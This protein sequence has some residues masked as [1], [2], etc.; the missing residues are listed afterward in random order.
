MSDIWRQIWNFKKKCSVFVKIQEKKNS[1][2]FSWK[3]NDRKYFGLK[4][5]E[6][7]W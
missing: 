3:N 5:W 7:F 4:G 2:L 6:N 1:N